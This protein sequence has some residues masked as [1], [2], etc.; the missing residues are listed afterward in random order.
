LAAI[1]HDEPEPSGNGWP[2]RVAVLSIHSSPIAPPGT[3][4]SGGM[5]VWVRAVASE[6]ARLGVE[7]DLFTRSTDPDLP[8]VMELEPG[9]RLLHLT[10][11]PA[12]PLPKETLPG[13][14][15]AFTCALMHADQLPV[16][17][18]I[19]S[20]YWLSGWVARIAAQRWKVPFLHSFHTLGR[21]KDQTIG[22]DEE[23]EPTARLLGEEKV[24]ASADRL[25]VPTPL[26]AAQLVD[27]YSASPGK[28]DV[29]GPGI[30]ARVFHPGDTGDARRA[31]AE[32]PLAGTPLGT[33]L[34]DQS[35]PLALL[36]F[37]GRLQ[38]LKGPDVAGE[39]LA[40]LRRA[41]PDL[42]VE[43]LVVGG[44]SGNGAGEPERLVKLAAAGGVADRVTLL[45]AQPQA[46]L[47]EVYRAAD[48]LLVP[49]RSESFGLVALEAQAC[50]TPVLATR[51]GGLAWAVGDATTGLLLPDRDPARWAAA[52]GALLASPRRLAAM[53]QAAAQFSR[54]HG[55]SETAER[56][57]GIYGGL[58]AADEPAT[59]L[60]S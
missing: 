31:L 19:H 47:A 3:G 41:R 54:A 4:D 7:S 24:A 8:P 23:P 1:L 12:E 34:T 26:E 48:L 36:A 20:H 38:P 27:L 17:D 29:V 45:P 56:L 21:V 2:R 16:Y 22:P 11:G 40:E 37:V 60:T 51:V 28:I 53:G 55:W 44:A 57:L 25:I 6:L 52:A 46:P 5:N 14:L 50:G 32:G 42:D 30:D 15:A 33:R 39:A 59:A 58:V 18:L 49:S 35:R 10:A 9:V 13:Y 43:L